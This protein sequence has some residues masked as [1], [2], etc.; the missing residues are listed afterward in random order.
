[1]WGAVGKIL[2]GGDVI[3]EGIELI[4]D[5]HTS[6]GEKVQAKAKAVERKM[7]AYEPFKIA[8]R[9][10]AL[11]FA[12]TFLLCFMISLGAVLYD[13]YQGEQV[14]ADDGSI[15]VST[16]VAVTALMA[17]FKLHWAMMIILGFYF[18]AGAGEGIVERMTERD[19]AKAKR[20][21][22]KSGNDG[23]QSEGGS[24]GGGPP[25]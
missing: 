8:Q 6:E 18:G 1:M 7:K 13:V 19:E 5:M 15:Q 14:I 3:S 24:R 23:A 22:G 4:D 10:L 12:F 20:N 25:R 21:Q 2:G 11:M 16:V 9:L 17:A